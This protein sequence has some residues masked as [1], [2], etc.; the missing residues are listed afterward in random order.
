MPQQIIAVTVLGDDR[1][2]IVADVT[3]AARRTSGATSRTPR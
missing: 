2:G 1:P 3:T